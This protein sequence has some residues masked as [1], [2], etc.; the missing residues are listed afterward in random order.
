MESEFCEN[1]EYV[2]RIYIE[3]QMNDTEP[4]TWESAEIAHAHPNSTC[5]FE[6]Y[7]VNYGSQNLIWGHCS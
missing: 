7:R 2:R 5:N 6:A 1:S 3:P 4:F